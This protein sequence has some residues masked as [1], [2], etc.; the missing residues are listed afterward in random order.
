MNA[1]STCF[2]FV[3]VAANRRH[4]ICKRNRCNIPEHIATD[5]YIAAEMEIDI[6]IQMTQ[7]HVLVHR[8][9]KEKWTEKVTLNKVI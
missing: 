7:E 6:V 1:F 8:F 9:K 4:V 3:R 2:F 5:V